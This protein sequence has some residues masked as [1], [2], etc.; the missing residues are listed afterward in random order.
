MCA[1]AEHYASNHVDPRPLVGAT[2]GL[3]EAAAYLTGDCPYYTDA[4]P[5]VLVDPNR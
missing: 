1:T 4:G 5:K 2:I 3:E